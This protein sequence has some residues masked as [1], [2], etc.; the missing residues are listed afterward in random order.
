MAK[1]E[2]SGEELRVSATDVEVTIATSI[3][4]D[5]PAE[6][7]GACCLRMAE[8]LPIVQGAPDDVLCFEH[9]VGVCTIKTGKCTYRLPAVSGAEFP[10]AAEVETDQY[11]EIDA[12]ALAGLIAHVASSMDTGDLRPNLAGMQWEIDGSHLRAVATDGHRLS[13]ESVAVVAAQGG[14]WLIPRKAVLEIAAVLADT[15]GDSNAVIR[16]GSN[17]LVME[18]GSV[19]LTAQLVDGQFPNWRQ[20]LPKEKPTL[21]VTLEAPGDLMRAIRRVTAV[22]DTKH[23]GV[24]LDVDS[25]SLR[26]GYLNEVTGAESHDVLDV[27]VVASGRECLTIGA[28]YAYVVDALKT[29]EGKVTLEFRD[30]LTPI[31]LRGDGQLCQVIMPMRIAA[32]PGKA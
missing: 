18:R 24:R 10:T 19:C 15:D 20:V 30:E 1:L 14:P 12:T 22:A 16:F 2:A 25:S 32:N 29:L 11:V 5:E 28:N 31:M 26:L 4:L 3:A 9:S 17:A 8:L 6:Q 27:G 23:T 21:E 13:E 7:P